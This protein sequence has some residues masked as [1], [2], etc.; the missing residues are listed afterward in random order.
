MNTRSRHAWGLFTCVVSCLGLSASPALAIEPAAEMRLIRVG[1][2]QYMSGGNSQKER[3]ALHRSAAAFPIFVSFVGKTNH[4]HVHRVTVTIVN[5]IEGNSVVRLKTAGPM[6]LISLP[7]G[8]YTMSAMS[9]GAEATHTQL[10]IEPGKPE[11]LKLSID[12]HTPPT[13]LASAGPLY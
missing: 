7:P 13:T 11:N 10:D 12:T 6:L 8:H 2:I 5:R 9:P 3:D 4:D 1:D